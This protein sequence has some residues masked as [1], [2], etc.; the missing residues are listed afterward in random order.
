MS[1]EDAVPDVPPGAEVQ[2]V[3]SPEEDPPPWPSPIRIPCGEESTE[4]LQQASPVTD[5]DSPKPPASSSQAASSHDAP[6]LM[7]S[8][9][10]QPPAPPA[11]MTTSKA[12]PP[13][14]AH[15]VSR[16]GWE[17]LRT[18]VN[19]GKIRFGN[20]GGAHRVYYTGL[21]RAKGLGK[22]AMAEYIRIHGPPPSRQGG[23]G[24]GKGVGKDKGQDKG[25]DRANAQG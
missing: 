18:G 22:Q 17:R 25:K 21:Y 23:K 1:W 24:I 15:A 2:D 16:A 6:A 9:K 12:P 3:P 19:G 14:K 5:D 4:E 20:S 7:T 8:C 11:L 10:S 13:A